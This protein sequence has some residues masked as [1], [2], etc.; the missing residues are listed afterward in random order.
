MEI[1][2]ALILFAG[3][4]IAWL[5]LPGSITTEENVVLES[6]PTVAA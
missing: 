1:A 6:A 2:I 5:V 4:L 3:M